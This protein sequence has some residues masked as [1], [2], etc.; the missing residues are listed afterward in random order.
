MERAGKGCTHQSET[1]DMMDA[2]EGLEKQVKDVYENVRSQSAPSTEIRRKMDSC[3]AVTGDLMGL[4]KVRMSEVGQ[5]DFDAKAESARLHVMLDRDYAQSVFGSSRT[6]ST[7][8]SH[9]SNHS[10]HS[11][12]SQSLTV[13]RAECA[14]QLAARRAEMKMEEAIAA[15]K[16]ELKKLE[17][18]R[19]L[20]VIAAK[21]KA[22]SDADSN[23][24]DSQSQAACDEASCPPISCSP[25][26]PRREIKKEQTCENNNDQATSTNKEASLVQALHDTMVLTRLPTPEPS[27]F[28]GDPLKFLEWRTSFKAL[29]ERRCIDPADRLFYLQKYLSGEARSVV[30]GSF[31][32]KDSEAYNQAWEALNARYGH[33]FAIQCAYRE[34]LNNWPKIG[35]RESVKL[36]QFSDF[37]TSCN[38]AMPHIKGLQ[39]LNDC[40]ENRKMLQKLPDWLTSRWNRHVT[41]QLRQTEEYPNFKAFSDFIANEADIA[42]N[43]V[44]SLQALRSPEEKSQ[45]EVKRTKA[46][47]FSTNVKAHET[48]KSTTVMKTYTVAENSS[49]YS[50]GS[51]K[52]SMSALSANPV[53]CL[54]CGESHSAHKCQKLS[55]KSVE[56]KKRFVF[57]NNLCFGCLRRGHNSKDCKN[58]ATCGVCKKPHPT[59]LH[60]DRSAAADASSS[61]AT[62]AEEN[63]SSLSC[64]IDK[65]EG[66]STSMIVPVW[67]SSATTLETET[68]VYALLDTQSSN[69]F[70][71][72]GVIE[73]MGAGTEPVKLKLTTMMGKDSIVQ[74]ERVSGLRIRGFSSKTFVNLPPAYTRDFIPLEHSHIPTPETAKRWRHLNQIAQEIPELMECEVGLLIGYDCPRALAPRQVITGGDYE[75]YGIKTD[76]GWS[77]VGNSPQVAKST[78]VTGLCHRVSVK[79]L[80]PLT[81]ANVIRALEADF[82][83]TNPGEKSISQD[84]IQF[85]QLLNERIKQNADGHLEMPLPFKTRPQ[86]P[87]NKHLALV[88]LKQ[89]KRKFEKHP[90]FKNDYVKF[91]DNVFKDGDAERAENQPRAGSVWYIPH[92]GVYHPRKPEKIRVVFDCSAKYDGTALNDH[93]L[94]GPDLTNGLTGV[95]CRFRKHLIALICDVEKM[96]HRFHVSS[97]DRDYLRFLWWE[98]GDSKTEPKEYRMRVHLFGAASSPGCANYGMKYLASQ[99]EKDYPAAAN[100]IKKHFYVDDGLISVDSVDTAIKLVKE[101]QKLCAK[102]RLH[103]HKFISNNRE[104]LESIPDSERA[105]GVQDVDLSR[106][107]LPVHTVL[108]VKWS[109]NSDTFSFNVSLDEKPATRRGILSTVASVFDPLGFL[110]PFLLL[111]KKIL[112]EMCQKGIGWDEQLPAE[113]KPQWENWLNDLENLQKLQI[114]RCF[115]PENLGKVQRMELHHF[116]DA[117]S[118]GYG[119]CSYIRVVTKDKVHCALVIGKARVAPTKVVTIPRLELTAAVVSAVG[120]MLKEELELKIDQIDRLTGSLSLH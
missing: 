106:E 2:V 16:Q 117:S 21:L 120:S 45:R 115:V 24:G 113:L 61:H 80:P 6:K 87:E 37:L 107:E 34:K 102:G 60:E 118:H 98:G 76:L 26:A 51:K 112:Q 25:P 7:V 92:Q 108:G 23:G 93:L 85:M 110:A 35:S 71:D 104:V 36:R 42:C 56:E 43:P 30:E 66:G 77:I 3:T 99:A 49:K 82:K 62:E 84:D 13:K 1:S 90:R 48:D 68:L 73:K 111:G 72:Q 33:P 79:E 105:S 18:Q 100:F 39:V 4:M 114:P 14:A 12:E 67:I 78:E 40:E 47:A 116:S 46:N 57:E 86:L 54:C 44:T 103:L 17:N 20:D 64:C 27:V 70:V 69:T 88:R 19:D 9:H 109:V 52:V 28:Y 83:D 15:Q 41:K 29:I 11:A 58:K 91:M 65:G 38:N 96:F 75:P 10:S 8:R 119:Q 101:A 94:A 32:R 59:P 22:Y 5:E 97:E 55:S 81:P 50:N 63:T 89:L 95:L 31:Y 53:T 74:S